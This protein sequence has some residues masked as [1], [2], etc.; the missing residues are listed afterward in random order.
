MPFF[1]FGG[2]IEPVSV[3]CGIDII[4]QH[5]TMRISDSGGKRKITTLKSGIKL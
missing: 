4:M 3:S 2:K 1:A 5:E